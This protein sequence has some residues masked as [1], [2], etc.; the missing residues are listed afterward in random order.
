MTFIAPECCDGDVRSCKMTRFALSSPCPTG[1]LYR[2]AKD[3]TIRRQVC[4]IASGIIFVRDVRLGSRCCD[5]PRILVQ[6]RHFLSS[7]GALL[8]SAQSPPAGD[9]IGRVWHQSLL[10]WALSGECKHWR[11]LVGMYLRRA[12]SPGVRGGGTAARSAAPP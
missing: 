8:Y 3:T 6:L 12:W 9:A 7:P 11:W 10:N 1:L 2:P 4:S 5:G